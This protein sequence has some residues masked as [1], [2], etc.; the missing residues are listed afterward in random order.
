MITKDTVKK[1]PGFFKFEIER[2]Y[3]YFSFSWFSAC[4]CSLW[5]V[6][7]LQLKTRR[8]KTLNSH[9][10][11][12]SSV[13]RAIFDWPSKVICDCIGFILLRS[14]IGLRKRKPFFQPRIFNPRLHWLI[15]FTLFHSVIGPKNSH[16]FIN[17]WDS[18]PKQL[19]FRQPCLLVFTWSSHWL[20]GYIFF[21]LIYGLY[22]YGFGFRTLNCFNCVNS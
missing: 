22:Y 16:Q 21:A 17:Q 1:I 6:A 20:L 10:G 11:I 5:S 18:K 13:L 14:V 8:F 7:L 4:S 2:A 19:R 3:I 12:A 9:Q 15:S